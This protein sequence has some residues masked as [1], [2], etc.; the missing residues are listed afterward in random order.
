MVVME[1]D[2]EQVSGRELVSVALPARRGPDTNWSEVQFVTHGN[3]I[4]T[5]QRF[6]S[7]EPIMERISTPDIWV[8]VSIV[9]INMLSDMFGILS[10]SI[11]KAAILLLSTS[12]AEAYRVIKNWSITA[13]ISTD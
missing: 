4:R 1:L 3:S 5:S 8:S 6:T 9:L 7:S 11:S 10:I 13:F 12:V 2:E